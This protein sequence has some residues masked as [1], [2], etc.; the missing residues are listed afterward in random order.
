[1]ELVKQT[2]N[3]SNEINRNYSDMEK[4]IVTKNFQTIPKQEE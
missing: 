2:I 3:M 1:M 4:R